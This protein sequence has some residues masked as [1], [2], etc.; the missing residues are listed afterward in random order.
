MPPTAT[1]TNP[2]D[3]AGA[4]EQDLRSYERVPRLLLESG[5]VDAVLLTGY[6]G[7]YSATSDELREPE[8]EAAR[9]LARAAAE[10]G[11]PAIVQTMYWQEAPA[12][13]LREAG[14][15]VYREIGAALASLAQVVERPAA[16]PVAELPELPTGRRLAG[17]GLLRGAG[18]AGRRRSPLPRG[19]A[20][21][22]PR[23]K[24][25]P[26]RP[27]SATRSS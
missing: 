27:S 22:R 9:G 8:T 24:R 19:P 14:V 17:R 25:R 1:T 16:T 15:P 4:G 7:G 23:T 11:R 13:A 12:L 2:V 21:R 26:R 5:E 18:P 20:G 6:L 3:F 10:A